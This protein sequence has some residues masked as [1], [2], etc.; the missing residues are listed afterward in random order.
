MQRLTLVLEPKLLS[1]L[2]HIVGAATASMKLA[3]EMTGLRR[4]KEAAP[5]ST[6]HDPREEGPAHSMQ[7]QPRSLA[8]ARA[9]E[10]PSL[11]VKVVVRHIGLGLVYEDVRVALVKILTMTVNVANY[12]HL[13]ERNITQGK[14]RGLELISGDGDSCDFSAITVAISDDGFGNMEGNTDLI[15]SCGGASKV[16]LD[17]KK[18]NSLFSVDTQNFR[19]L[20]SHRSDS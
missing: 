8:V 13:P 11:R 7:S 10:L 2:L 9:Q 20:Y 18:T 14:V 4:P 16:E 1:R 12:S 3:R 19:L 15:Q 17:W 5:S 6:A